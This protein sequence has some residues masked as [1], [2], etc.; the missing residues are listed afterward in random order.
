MVSKKQANDIV[1]NL[2]KSGHEMYRN[3]IAEDLRL[4]QSLTKKLDPDNI[5][6]ESKDLYLSLAKDKRYAR[7]SPV[8][9]VNSTLDLNTK[10][11]LIDYVNLQNVGYIKTKVQVYGGQVM[12]ATRGENLPQDALPHYTIKEVGEKKIIAQEG[13]QFVVISSDGVARYGR[14]G[15][16]QGNDIKFVTRE[17]SMGVM[18]TNLGRLV[19]HRFPKASNLSTGLNFMPNENA[20]DFIDLKDHFD[21][22]KQ[23]IKK[24]SKVLLVKKTGII[25]DTLSN[26]FE[27]LK[28]NEWTPPLEYQD[29]TAIELYEDES[30]FDNMYMWSKTSLTFASIGSIDWDLIIR[31]KSR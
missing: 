23:Q 22:R 28:D 5:T 4:I 6:Q 7:K 14:G 26:I 17:D 10:E 11:R 13:K 25:K 16:F 29:L 31:K 15:G 18:L 8:K 9:F 1:A 19:F 21:Y 30:E 2:N 3:R 24:D 20:I 27:K 12:L